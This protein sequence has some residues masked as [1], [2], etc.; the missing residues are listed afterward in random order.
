MQSL[1]LLLI[2]YMMLTRFL[3]LDSLDDPSALDLLGMSWDTLVRIVTRCL[4]RLQAAD[5]DLDLSIPALI[6]PGNGPVGVAARH[7]VTSQ[8][9]NTL[10]V[11][12]VYS[13]SRA[14]LGLDSD[15]YASISAGIGL[16]WR[17]WIQ[18]LPV[19]K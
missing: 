6:N 5:Q 17:L 12:V 16:C 1:L 15:A 7:R 18:P 3:W 13:V 19:S 11:C 2:V 14:R 4:M 8:L 10:K 9:A